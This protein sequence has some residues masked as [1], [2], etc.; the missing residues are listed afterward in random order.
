MLGHLETSAGD[1]CGVLVD[2]RRYVQEAEV[3]GSE[4]GWQW[5]EMAAVYE[6]AICQSTCSFLLPQFIKTGV[7]P[8]SL[9]HSGTSLPTRTFVKRIYCKDGKCKS[10][11]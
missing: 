8:L 1:V 10:P 9:S 11:H 5:E 7:L 4:G 6:R 3:E 2:N